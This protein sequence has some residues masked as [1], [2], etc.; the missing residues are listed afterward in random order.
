MSAAYYAL[1]HLLV[2]EGA[3]RL[4]PNAP[5]RLRCRYLGHLSATP[6]NAAN[7]NV[8]LAARLFNNRWNK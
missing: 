4:I 5:A 8:F 7:A 6:R 2:S 3:L 1:F